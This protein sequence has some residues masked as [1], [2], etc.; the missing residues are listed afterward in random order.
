MNAT[1]EFI[2]ASYCVGVLALALMSGATNAQ[3]AR[4]AGPTGPADP[5]SWIQFRGGTDN[6]G[7]VHGALEASWKFKAP[8]P[9]RGL[10]VAAGLVFLGTES[11]DADAAMDAFAPDQRGILIA[12]DAV[13]GEP[14]WRRSVPSWI[15][16]DPA[17][18]RGRTI[19]TFGRWPM[20][21]AGGAIA[22]DSHTG[23]TLWSFNTAA[24]IMP[25]PVIDT[26]GNAVLVVGGDGVLY[27]LSMVDGAVRD[28]MGLQSADAMSSPRIDE[29]RN[30]YLGT[31]GEVHSVSAANGRTNWKYNSKGLRAMLDVP[32]ALSDSVV[33]TVGTHQFGFWR[34]AQ[35]LSVRRFIGMVIEARRSRPISTYRAWFEQQWLLAVDRRSGRLLW[36]HKLGVG[37]GVPRNTAGTPVL[38]GNRVIVSS[39]VSR[40][41][42]AF[43][44]ST[45]RVAWSRELHSMHKGAVTAVG[46][47]II[48][49]DKNGNLFF[50]RVHDGQVVGRC[51]AGAPFTPLAPLV[52]GRTVL[53]ATHD[54]WVH[55]V[56]YDSLRD[57]ATLREGPKCF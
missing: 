3:S 1:R 40:T 44:A 41:I 4:P 51:A 10:A 28:V 9:V 6:S 25:S 5:R 55:A 13:T 56:P 57:R 17:T 54:G 48:F 43:N 37:L 50:L 53:I 45:G 11:A 47:E 38:V 35:S 34:A 19:V 26:T 14:V 52:V 30:V 12:L 8:H 49:G 36:R 29:H 21:S 24:G 23:R 32:V 31:M 27:N 20:T 7:N 15:H 18:F 39:P 16:G 33:F 42:W 2:G 22:V 46:D